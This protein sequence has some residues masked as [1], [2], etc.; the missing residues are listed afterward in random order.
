ATPAAVGGTLAYMAPEHL[1]ALAEGGSSQVG[2]RSD[3]YALGVVLFDCLVRGTR[4]FALPSKSMT[5][6][7]ALR[8]A[9]EARRGGA[10]RLRATRPDGPRAREGVGRR[11]RAPERGDRYAWAAQL[12]ADLQ[13]AAD[14]GPLRF[15]R[16][17][18][19][20]RCVRWTRRNRRR[21]VVAAVLVLALG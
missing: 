3:L 4:S 2:S 18:I 20:S 19:P 5:M 14:D 6:T 1:E 13:A 11:C 16:E 21:L 10:P 17:P 9:A 15:A 12:A 8:R 7:E